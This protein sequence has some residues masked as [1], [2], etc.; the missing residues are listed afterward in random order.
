MLDD[1]DLILDLERLRPMLSD[2]ISYSF[3]NGIGKGFVLGL[4]PAL[5]P[6]TVFEDLRWFG[7]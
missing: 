2:G 5:L 4:S 3:A 6:L 7:V 1:G